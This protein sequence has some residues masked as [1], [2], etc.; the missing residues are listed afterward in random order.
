MSV[1]KRFGVLRV[2]GTLLKV[3]AW[4]VL[5]IAILGAI[6]LGLTS[7]SGDLVTGLLGPV[8][9]Q[10]FLGALGPAGGILAGV[11]FLIVGLIYFLITYAAGESLHLQLALEENTRLTAA[12]L[13][14]MHQESHQS[15]PRSTYGSSGFASDPFER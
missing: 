6:G 11:A 7:M 13:L 2:M 10:D 4:I 14:R 8:V 9:P 15:D 5:I 3:L 12:L 1:P